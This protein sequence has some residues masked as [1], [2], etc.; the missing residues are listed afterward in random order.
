MI[1]LLGLMLLISEVIMI[2]DVNTLQQIMNMETQSEMMHR[3]LSQP[4][5]IGDA[6]QGVETLQQIMRV[7]PLS[8]EIQMIIGDKRTPVLTNI[9]A[10]DEVL[11]KASTIM[12]PSDAA[13]DADVDKFI[14]NADDRSDDVINLDEEYLYEDID[15]VDDGRH[16]LSSAFISNQD[17]FTLTLSPQSTLK[18]SPGKLIFVNFILKN[19]GDVTKFFFK[20]G[21]GNP[22]DTDD[23]NNNQRRQRMIFP[24][25]TSFLQTLNPDNVLLD[26]NQSQEIK[27]GVGVMTS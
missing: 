24:G 2:T 14:V 17:P 5:V 11:K 18:S 8:P 7:A 12:I 26:R 9:A 10:D 21:V 19:R 1:A 13:G 25:Q 20:A 23:D 27:M 3:V 4:R 15:K 16:S 22:D 6:E